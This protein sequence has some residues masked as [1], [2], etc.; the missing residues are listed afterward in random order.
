MP[1]FRRVLPFLLLPLVACEPSGPTAN[2]VVKTVFITPASDT[3]RSIGETRQLT[4]SALDPRD[5]LIP[6]PRFQWQS[7]DPQIATVDSAGL[8]IAVGPGIARIQAI[9]G[10]VYGTATITV[11]QTPDRIG[12]DPSI[13]GDTLR[14]LGDTRQLPA[15]VTDRLGHPIAGATVQWQSSRPE[16]AGV[17]PDGRLTA[18]GNGTASLTA[19]AG[20]VRATVS[21]VVDQRPDHIAF[22]QKPSDVLEGDALPTVVFGIYDARNNLVIGKPVTT[23]LDVVGPTGNVQTLPNT[24]TNGRA[25]FERII[26][27]GAGAGQ[28][29]KASGVGFAAEAT[30]SFNVHFR[31]VALSGGDLHT[32]GLTREGRAYCWGD[33][34]NGQLGAGI[35]TPS[36]SAP[37]RVATTQTFAIIAAG[38][39][40][41][42]ALTAD[43]TPWC[44]GTPLTNDPPLLTPAAVSSTVK[45]KSLVNRGFPCGLSKDG[46]A[47]CWYAPSSIFDAGSGGPGPTRVMSSLPLPL[48]AVAGGSAHVCALDLAG[49]AF[50]AGNNTHGELGDGNAPTASTLP[51]PVAISQPF[52][53]IALGDEFACALTAFGVAYCWG[54]NAEGQL[55][56]GPRVAMA[57]TPAFVTGGP[58]KPL[59]AGAAHVCGNAPILA[60]WG[61]FMGFTPTFASPQAGYAGISAGGRH[62]C[63]IGGDGFAYCWGD[64]TNGQL[65]TGDVLSRAVPTLI[66]APRAR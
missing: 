37:T 66:A 3:L 38:S 14:S 8:V 63:A 24:T 4:A 34:T 1:S 12:L 27:D 17:T 59:S 64:G 10:T 56:V 47:F 31:F 21:V 44:W 57:T 42:C 39:S 6:G 51:V 54:N 25:I 11:T 18:V 48:N 19:A 22:I 46:A 50:C 60:C 52:A 49:R 62:T 13:S 40:T 35:P 29:L 7:L 30:A 16:I 61:R 26:P 23:T 20:P 55:G 43:G 33:N 32:C 2:S 9:D 36:T 5:R 41:T 58:F 65:G 53:S 45:L 15:T 28:L